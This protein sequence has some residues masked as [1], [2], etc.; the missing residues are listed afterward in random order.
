[1]FICTFSILS[2]T[3]TDNDPYNAKRGFF[4]SHCG[5]LLYKNININHKT[6]SGNK[7]KFK[8]DMSDIKSNKL[9]QW[10]HK[11]YFWFAPLLTIILPMLV[12]KI[13][14]NDM[15]GGLFYCG[16]LKCVYIHHRTWV[17]NSIAHY[18][19]NTTYDDT[20]SA[21]DHLIT[22]ILSLGEGYH[23][24][25]HEFPSDYRNGYKWWNYDPTKWFIYFCYK[26]GLVYQLNTFEENE[27]LRGELDMKQK[28][29]NCLKSKINYGRDVV[30][31]PVWSMNKCKQIAKTENKVLI[32]VDHIVCVFFLYI[33][34]YTCDTVQ[35]KKYKLV[36]C[37]LYC[38]IFLSCM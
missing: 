17:V 20:V 8:I 22:S 28:Q 15:R 35:S 38:M 1:M 7:Y 12:A 29:L 14:W 3:D 25:H 23:N 2:L 16:F 33:F 5:W 10:Q 27:I 36:C 19:G 18:F 34:V 37:V 6:T 4:Y 11:N 24:F 9:L 13:F 26:I 31:L 21:R 32:I 30:L